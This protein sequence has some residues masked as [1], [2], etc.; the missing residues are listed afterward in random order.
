MSIERDQPWEA[1]QS[2]LQVV[3]D[4]ANNDELFFEERLMRKREEALS[5]LYEALDLC[6]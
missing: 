4:Q 2:D 3:L 5:A 1:F 6:P